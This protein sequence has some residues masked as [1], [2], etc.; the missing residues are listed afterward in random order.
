MKHSLLL[1]TSFLAFTSSLLGFT[2]VGDLDLDGEPTIRDMVLLNRHLNGSQPLE[3]A[4][5]SLADI[6]LDGSVNGADLIALQNTILDDEELPP[7]PWPE[8]I[9]ASPNDGEA[10]V[11][12]TRETIFRFDKPLP[13]NAATTNAVTASFGGTTLNART[14]LSPDRQTL[15]LFYD[16]LL[17]ASARVRVAIDGDLLGGAD[18]NGDGYRGGKGTIDFDTLSLTVLENTSV[19]GRVFASNPQAA[20][21]GLE[22]VNVPLTGVRITVDGMEDTLFAVTDNMG[23]FTLSPC[24]AGRFFVHID[25]RTVTGVPAGGYYPFVGKT[26]TSTPN[27]NTAVGDVYLPLIEPDTLQTVNVNSETEI[28]FPQSVREADPRLAGTSITVPPNALFSDNG[29]RGGSVGIA[30]VSPDRLPGEL[31][32]GLSFPLVVTVQ[33]DGATNFDQPAQICFP[34]LPDPDTGELLLPGM[35]AA[36]WSFNHDT[37]RFEIAGSMT[38]SE[39]GSMICTD[40]GVGVL[41]PGWHGAR[42][43]TEIR[44]KAPNRSPAKDPGCKNASYWDIAKLVFNVTKDV[45]A[46]GATIIGADDIFNCANGVIS[47]A[48]DM[49]FTIKDMIDDTGNP[50]SWKRTQIG[51]AAIKNQKALMKAVFDCFQD[52]GP[53]DILLDAVK[54]G[55]NIIGVADSFCAFT[56]LDPN[57]PERCRPTSATRYL[58][59]KVKE[60]KFAFGFFILGAEKFKQALNNFKIAATCTLIEGL[61]LSFNGWPVPSAPAAQEKGNGEGPI[62]LENEEGDRPLTEA[63]L[64]ELRTVLGQLETELESVIAAGEQLKIEQQKEAADQIRRSLQ[65]ILTA[66]AGALSQSGDAVREPVYYVF[67]TGG[68]AVRGLTN[69]SGTFRRNAAAAADYFFAQYHPASNSY[70]EVTGRTGANGSVSELP[71]VPL[72]SAAGLTD[73]DRD[74]LADAVEYVLGTDPNDPDS[75][76]DGI[77]DLAE[78][79]QGILDNTSTGVGII[80]SADTPGTAVDVRAFNDLV[81]VADS[82]AGVSVFNVFNGMNPTIVAQVDTPGTASAVALAD[83]FLAVADGSQGLAIIDLTDPPSAQIIHQVMLG[84]NVISVEALG[85][86]AYAGLE[87]G[88]LPV[89]DLE[90]GAL[91]DQLS[92]GAAI[93]DI[94][95]SGDF[96]YVLTASDL[97]AVALDGT[98]E[99][100]SQAASRGT[101]NRLIGRKRLFAGAGVAYVVE[102]RGYHTYDITNP[103]QIAL[104]TDAQ[105]PQFGWKQLVTNGSGTG[106]ATVSPNSTSDGGHH[107][108]LY[109]VRNTSQNQNFLAEIETPGRATATTIN[110]AI[111]YVADGT[112]GLHAVRY[113][114]PDRGNTAP[115]I[116]VST[117]FADG[118]AE[119]GQWLRLTADVSDD[120]EVRNVQLLVDGEFVSS[121]GNYPFEFRYLTPLIAEGAPSF[122]AQLRA[123]DT[124]GNVT[125][126]SL[127]TLVLTKDATPPRATRFRPADGAFLGGTENVVITFNEP[128]DPLSIHSG[129]IRLTQGGN[130]VTTGVLSLQ[131]DG[132]TTV[133]AFSESLPDGIYRV[134]VDGVTDLA[135]NAL[136]PLTFSFE[137]G[138]ITINTEYGTAR[139]PFQP[140]ANAL[141]VITIESRDL[142][143]NSTVTFPT[144]SR[145]GAKGERAAKVTNVSGGGRQA[146]VTV[147]ADACTGVVL[148][149]DGRTFYLQIVPRITSIDGGQGRETQ[150]W[151]SGFIEGATTVRFGNQS[152]VVDGGANTDDGIDVFDWSFANQRLAVTVPN[153]AALPYE[154]IT[155]GGFSGTVNDVTTLESVS[156]TGTAADPEQA[157]ANVGQMVTMIG[158]G[159]TEETRVTLEAMSRSG[160]PYITTITPD[161]VAE[162]GTSVQFT[163]PPE[164][165]TGSAGV[166][167]GGSGLLLQIVPRIETIDGGRGRATNIWGSGFIESEISVRFGSN[168]STVVDG[169]PASDDG[170]DVFDW[171]FANQRL[172]VTAPETA[173]LP[174]EVITA[175]GSSGRITDVT[176]VPTI[177]NTGTPADILEASANVGQQVTLQGVGYVADETRVV[178]EAMSRAGVPYITTVTPDEIAADGRSLIFTVPPEARTGMVTLKTG[179]SGKI[180]QIV[181]RIDTI[182]GGRGRAT[183]IWGSGFI[184]GEIHIRFGSNDSIVVDG[185]PNSDDGID[186]FDW[187]F[188]NQRLAVTVPENAALPYEVITEGGS[189]GRVTDVTEVISRAT[190]GTPHDLNEASAN[191]FQTVTFRGAGYDA[192]STKIVLE[193]MNRSGV[194][195]ITTIN[196]DSVSP[197]GMELTFT[198]PAEARTGHATLLT[199]GAGKLLQIVPDTST[200]DG[201][202]G[203]VTQIWGTGFTEGEISVRFGPAED[204]VSVMDGGPASDDGIDVFDWS[205]ANQRLSLTVPAGA[206]LP[207]RV[208]TEGGISGSATDIV[209]LNATATTGTPAVNGTASANIGQTLTLQGSGFSEA[210]KVTFEAIWHDGVPY[211]L[212]ANPSSVAPD[213]NSLT[214]IVPAG[215]VTGNVSLLNG[216]AAFR[217]LIVPVISSIS[218][219][220]TAGNSVT[221]IGGG[222]VDGGTTVMFGNASVT[223]PGVASDDGF[224]V[225]NWSSRNDRLRATVPGGGGTPIR[226]QTSGGTSNAFTP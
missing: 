106:L 110:N 4:E 139:D 216:G 213:G 14:H 161:A 108:S 122:T 150:I 149:P 204:S 12:I 31:P 46:C 154:V 218:G 120:V 201:G 1:F 224:D 101:V 112:S 59:Q 79:Q 111:A 214:I 194:P 186:V 6:D 13:A 35:K 155:E 70:G 182:D 104:I 15:T 211:I 140:S 123:T 50:P 72:E 192:N 86:T 29:T 124:A 141:Q 114:E 55:Q 37:G 63:E 64:A 169:G 100:L 144:R 130:A 99:I 205:F 5:L 219:N 203:Q 84:A 119:E 17:P 167:S 177:S 38:V 157:S 147:P 113:L 39:D 128:A 49:L 117:N 97:F 43:G 20:E 197:N 36:L 102:R 41:A 54:C 208:I 185:G 222:Y 77:S 23:N 116:A 143:T 68:T 25:G 187:S 28:T 165:R 207:Y 166:L 83:Q 151:G 76:D 7:V 163:I 183:N 3:P 10:G 195:Y 9:E 221:V 152:A 142:T 65:E 27:T 96:L 180:L 66:T 174:Y 105:T 164:A 118:L 121:D 137:I 190:S 132:L 103:L 45:V 188:A 181:P 90:S 91:L 212:T 62:I 127:L 42:P 175:G 138:E 34:N 168:E 202:A 26:W 33:T 198:V 2:Q 178:L 200:I 40:P 134:D 131:A 136:P 89:I 73:T 24:P 19:S 209:S 179:G 199:G 53:A 135:G 71:S 52:A 223:D 172:A 125:D 217:L 47:S 22:F 109:N 220:V 44:G 51:I 210:T 60:A 11:A 126:S 129:S 159:F 184:E 92:F 173:M 67:Q 8:L 156:N 69:S 176:A 193:A 74:G 16:D 196:P 58:C 48:G 98:L 95:G 225:F 78:V 226:V 57:Q 81:A 75:D 18:A 88:E 87:N 148:M 170:I 85:G 171:S 56:D 158:R 82:D 107:L 94:R 189:S 191:V 153:N 206:Q 162:N 80:A 32:E 160:V 21:G 145:S 93:H 115:T 215:V 146:D 30:P 133:M 61:D